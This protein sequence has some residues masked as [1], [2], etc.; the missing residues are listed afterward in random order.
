MVLHQVSG[1]SVYSSNTLLLPSHGKKGRGKSMPLGVMMGASR[2]QK[3]PEV[4]VLN[5]NQQG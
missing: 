1:L 4:A 2:A 5:S 3:Q